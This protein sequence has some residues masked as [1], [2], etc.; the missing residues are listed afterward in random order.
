MIGLFPYH[1]SRQNSPGR[2]RSSGKGEFPS[3][4][5]A[6]ARRTQSCPTTDFSG[7]LHESLSRSDEGE[8]Y[9][10]VDDSTVG[11]TPGG[12]SHMSDIGVAV[13][14]LSLS[15]SAPHN[16]LST[17]SGDPQSQRTPIPECNIPSSRAVSQSESVGH[18]VAQ[19]P[20]PPGYPFIVSTPFAFQKSNEMNPSFGSG[21]TKY[22]GSM[23][24]QGQIDK[25]HLDLGY[26][27]HANV[28]S[29]AVATHQGLATQ[30]D[31]HE[32]QPALNPEAPNY[33]GYGSAVAGSVPA[34]ANVGQVS[35]KQSTH[36]PYWHKFN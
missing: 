34:M 33:Q 19:D 31:F 22:S 13:D 14:S 17:P 2:S 3:L 18:P 4:T 6:G 5:M 7:S 35:R 28:A 36:N 8:L 16:T 30:A 9:T 21:A 12:G 32:K 25:D 24:V 1:C 11:D 29:D 26:N 27:A 23:S 20:A 10:S 15:P